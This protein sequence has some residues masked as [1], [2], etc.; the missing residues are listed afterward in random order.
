MCLETKKNGEK[1]KIRVGFVS[2]PARSGWGSNPDPRV[3]SGLTRNA[4]TTTASRGSRLTLDNV[5]TPCKPVSPRSPSRLHLPSSTKS[6]QRRRVRQD[7]SLGASEVNT[8]ATCR[9]EIWGPQT[10]LGA[11][12][13]QKGQSQS[14][15][16]VAFAV[17][18]LPE[19]QEKIRAEERL[20][21]MASK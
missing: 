8:S 21:S 7:S 9:T 13:A 11:E 19:H 1:P 15:S 2:R 20:A 18:T 3:G 6:R 10:P 12:D 16:R 14:Q 17:E 4:L 5:T